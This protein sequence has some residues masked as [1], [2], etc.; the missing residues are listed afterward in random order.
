MKYSVISADN[1]VVEPPETFVDRV[2][3][4]LK[5]RV[6]RVLPGADGGDGWSFDGGPPATTFTDRRRGSTLLTTHGG[7][8]WSEIPRGT[9]DGAEHLKDMLL[10]GVDA[11]VLYPDFMRQVYEW[12][13]REVG[14]ACLRAYNDWLLEDF[15][16]VDPNRLIGMCILPT[17]DGLDELVN[18]ARRALEAGAKGFF[19][20]Y[21]PARPL[22]D[23]YYDPLWKLISASGAV[24]SLHSGFG[25]RRP[26]TPPPVPTGVD[27]ANIGTSRAIQSY[28][29]AIGPLTDIIFGGT[30]ERFPLLKILAAEVNA[31]WMPY[32][33]QEMHDTSQRGIRRGSRP[34]M[35]A[36]P[37]EYVGRNVFVTVLAD[38]VGFRFAKED[39]RLRNAMLYS[40]DYQHSITL[41]PHSQ[42]IIPELTQGMD[43]VTKY[44]ILAGNAVK[45]FN[46]N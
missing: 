33:M 8:R 25:G 32:W 28:F 14:L 37:D 24:A 1:H 16:A 7:L 45:I 10:D 3:A 26:F 13:D 19:L 4:N 30:F 15:C 35:P 44:N 36:Q 23:P 6:P 9:Y 18:E 12:P 17:D 42:E 34:T 29:S 43:E 5:D 40:T 2:P 41:W 46:L 21:F 27:A 22:Y 11:A 38:R 20:P 31:G 39:S